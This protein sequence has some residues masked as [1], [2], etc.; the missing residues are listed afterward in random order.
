MILF[1]H[2]F[3]TWSCILYAQENLSDLSRSLAVE[4]RTEIW[5]GEPKIFKVSFFKL[6]LNSSDVQKSNDSSRTNKSSFCYLCIQ[7]FF[8]LSFSYSLP[9]LFLVSHQASMTI[10]KMKYKSSHLH[11]S[12]SEGSKLIFEPWLWYSTGS[13]TSCSQYCFDLGPSI[14]CIHQRA[15]RINAQMSLWL[16]SHMV[17]LRDF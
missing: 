13:T 1:K 2:F 7:K 3:W 11:F 14:I 6:S 16:S 17:M 9:F 4:C 10:S 15:E 8:I 5:R 12:D